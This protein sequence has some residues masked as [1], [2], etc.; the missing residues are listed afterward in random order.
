MSSVMKDKKRLDKFNFAAVNADWQQVIGN[1]GPPCF[2]LDKRDSH[3][4][5]RAERWDGHKHDPIHEYVPLHELIA[6]S[7][8]R[9]AEMER[10]A[11]RKIAEDEMIKQ[12]S[13][14]KPYTLAAGN[15]AEEIANFIR[16]RTTK[17]VRRG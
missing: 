2:Y 13:L 12:R 16:L 17:K 6:Q 11:C 3:F 5:L 1:G 15:T 7:E 14:I 4:C 8:Q 10:E 9:G